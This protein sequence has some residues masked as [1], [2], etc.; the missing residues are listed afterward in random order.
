M[1]RNMKR[2]HLHGSADRANPITEHYLTILKSRLDLKKPQYALLW[3]VTSVT[4]YTMVHFGEIL[5]L[6][7]LR[8]NLSI[9]LNQLKIDHRPKGLYAT[10][11]LPH[12]KVHNPNIKATLAIWTDGMTVCPWAALKTYLNF[13]LS[14]EYAD[15]SDA[16]WCIEN[17]HAINKH[18]F[19]EALKTCLPEFSFTGHSFRAGGATF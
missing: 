11:M 9:R 5:P 6:D 10:M 17:S 19:L 4:F 12:S 16:L 18:W 8:I 15:D 7:N 3:A 2:N 1:I 13:R 14:N